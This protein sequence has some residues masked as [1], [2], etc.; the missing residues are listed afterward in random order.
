[1]DQ[2][3]PAVSVI[4]TCPNGCGAAIGSLRR[5]RDQL[6]PRDELI[7]I[8][9]RACTNYEGDVRHLTSSN[10]DDNQMTVEGFALAR[11]EVVLVLEDHALIGP[12]FMRTLREVFEDSAVNVATFFVGNGTPFG[13]GSQ[14]LFSFMYG[15]ASPK[16]SPV[17]REM[18]AASFAI[19][20]ER[21]SEWLLGNQDWA[22]A[23]AIRTELVPNL[24]TATSLQMPEALC[25]LHCQSVSVAQAVQAV[26]LNAFRHGNLEKT[27][28][29]RDKAK[30]HAKERY[31]RRPATLRAVVKTDL[32]VMSAIHLLAFSAWCGW[33][34]GRY[35]NHVDIGSRMAK[36][37][38][39][40]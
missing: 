2:P 38:S 36:L 12:E 34:L 28:V 8:E 16:V 35:R 30:T 4:L 24:V 13:I 17:N 31:L 14:A 32:R 25:L 3:Q 7:V 6:G 22:R 11:H 5:V 29:A 15:F 39:H 27:V 18:V 20:R 33:W 37:H 23:G 9:P 19:R 1:M 10:R 26:Y 40:V 21:L